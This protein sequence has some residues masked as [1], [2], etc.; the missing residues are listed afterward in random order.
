VI[1]ALPITAIAIA[2]KEPV[3][4]IVREANIRKKITNKRYNHE[5]ENEKY[6]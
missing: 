6:Y 2:A 3:I 1:H 4:T 5:C